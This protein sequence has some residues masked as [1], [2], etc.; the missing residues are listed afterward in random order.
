MYVN[1]S[2]TKEQ[3]NQGLSMIG[4]K[5]VHKLSIRLRKSIGFFQHEF[6]Y[7]YMKKPSKELKVN[8]W[9]SDQLHELS[10]KYLLY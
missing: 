8:I 6:D 9:I 5:H 7:E 2:L 1:L 10:N 4:N 3:I